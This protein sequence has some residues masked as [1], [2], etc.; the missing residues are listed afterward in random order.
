L[1]AFLQPFNVLSYG[2]IHKVAPRTHAAT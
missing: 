2:V 1:L